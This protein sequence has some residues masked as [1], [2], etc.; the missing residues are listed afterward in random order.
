MFV[1]RDSLGLTNSETISVLGVSPHSLIKVKLRR[2]DRQSLQPAA[3]LNRW[4]QRLKE[5]TVEDQNQPGTQIQIHIYNLRLMTRLESLLSLRL[6]IV[7]MIGKRPDNL[8]HVFA[9]N[10]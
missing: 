1:T 6:M 7:T 4:K 8:S 2:T 10:L 5:R 3:Q 9:V